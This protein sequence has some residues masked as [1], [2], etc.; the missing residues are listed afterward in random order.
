MMYVI[1]FLDR[2]GQNVFLMDDAYWSINHEKPHVLKKDHNVVFVRKHWESPVHTIRVKDHIAVNKYA[3]SRKVK[4][5]AKK[6]DDH[7]TRASSI[8]KLK[9]KSLKE[10]T[11]SRPK[12]YQ[13]T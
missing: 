3:R 1:I 4:K 11:V 9:R 13:K 2:S 6:M 5:P 8:L 7:P 12:R 10:N